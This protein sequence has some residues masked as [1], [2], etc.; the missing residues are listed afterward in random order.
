MTILAVLL[1]LGSSF[2]S[3]QGVYFARDATYSASP[4]YAA[5]DTHGVQRMFA[6]RVAVGEYCA[7]VKDA[8]IPKERNNQTHELYDSTVD[9]TRDPSIYIT[10]HDAQAYPEVSAVVIMLA[11]S[12][13]DT[14][15]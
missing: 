12:V 3:R 13:T 8:I 10:Y 15:C 4:T 2:S 11:L 1:N 6:C 9:K 5:P 7:G 14:V